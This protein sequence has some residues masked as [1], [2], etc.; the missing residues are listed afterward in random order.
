M[1]A[2]NYGDSTNGRVQNGRVHLSFRPFRALW[3]QARDL[4]DGD[5]CKLDSP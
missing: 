2:I 5:L 4:I 3:Q 1:G